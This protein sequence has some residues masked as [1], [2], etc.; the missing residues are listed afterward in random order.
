VTVIDSPHA[1]TEPRLRLYSAIIPIDMIP[2]ILVIVQFFFHL[3]KIFLPNLS[4]QALI[5]S[6]LMIIH[7][8]I[9]FTSLVVWMATFWISRPCRPMMATV[10]NPQTI[11]RN[12][13]KAT[14]P[15]GRTIPG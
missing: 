4:R 9:N 1:A 14:L 7:L 11:S 10:K 2:L 15:F 12:H 6:L 3:V 5:S 13:L 8:I